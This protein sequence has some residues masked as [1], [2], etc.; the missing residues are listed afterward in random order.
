[1]LN[2]GIA[3]LSCNALSNPLFADSTANAKETPSQKEL[4]IRS[5]ANAYIQLIEDANEKTPDAQSDAENKPQRTSEEHLA[6]A[7][8]LQKQGKT[9]EALTHSQYALILDPT[10]KKAEQLSSDLRRIFDQQTK[11][12]AR[13]QDLVVKAKE[14]EKKGKTDR[15]KKLW[16]KASRL[17]PNNGEIA[18][19]YELIKTTG[20]TY[21]G[22]R[23]RQVEPQA[24]ELTQE[25]VS[26]Y[27]VSR[28]DVIEVFVWQNEDLS[29]NVVVRPDG[30]ISIPLVG[31]VSAAGKTLTQLDEDITER[32][33]T[34]I[35]FPDVS[36]AIKRFGGTKTLVLGEVA[37]PGV[38]IPSGEGRI[39]EVIA[40]AGGFTRKAV[41]ENIVLIRGGM[42][43][44]QVAKLNLDAVIQD[45]RIADNVELQPNDIIYVPK[46]H[47]S[48]L[49]DFMDQFSPILTN[50]LL[51]TTLSTTFGVYETSGGA[52]QR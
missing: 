11:L 29:R 14:A 4:I 47:I 30:R 34:Y 45:G 42:Q 21:Q 33:Q 44:P 10:N 32:L 7:Y 46:K 35:R 23:A 41:G 3:L 18:D 39:L 37:N 26:E 12:K 40:L 22:L 15:A 6:L 13:V 31:D 49:A 2:L 1:M 28:G 8:A 16:K 50:V 36:L 38:Y 20:S 51:G 25:S 43:N 19:K 27:L 5:A 48:S 24:L 9:F 52:A 17:D